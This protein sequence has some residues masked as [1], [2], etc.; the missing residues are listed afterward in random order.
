MCQQCERLGFSGH[1]GGYTPTTPLGPPP[2]G[3]PLRAPSITYN[4]CLEHAIEL[5]ADG[6]T[7]HYGRQAVLNTLAAAKQA[8]ANGRTG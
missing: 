1:S 8:R 5:L 4:D 7:N 3:D 6:M 2:Q